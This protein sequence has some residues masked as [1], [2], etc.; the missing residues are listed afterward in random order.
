[1]RVTFILNTRNFYRAYSP[2][3]IRFV[4]RHTPV[5]TTF[6]RTNV[7]PLTFV[8]V[9][10]YCIYTTP[11]FQVIL[12]QLSISSSSRLPIYIG[13][14]NFLLVS[15]VFGTP[16]ARP[17]LLFIRRIYVPLVISMTASF[18]IVIGYGIVVVAGLDFDLPFLGAFEGWY[19]GIICATPDER[20]IVTG[21]LKHHG[22]QQVQDLLC[23]QGPYGRFYT[24]QLLFHAYYGNIPITIINYILSY[25]PGSTRIVS[26]CLQG[27]DG[28]RVLVSYL[29]I[30]YWADIHYLPNIPQAPIIWLPYVP[31]E[32]HIHWRASFLADVS[33]L[34]DFNRMLEYSHSFGYNDIIIPPLEQMDYGS[35][36][37]K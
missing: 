11:N 5:V 2:P 32:F 15:L 21:L 13:L 12:D 29:G 33:H 25:I 36:P 19:R 3:V 23:L 14:G 22:I 7:R 6:I 17:S 34:Y 18:F 9:A 4:Q 8:S 30:F 37:E 28:A 27:L 24:N 35:P 1:M 31:F 26:V 10:G 20:L 16:N